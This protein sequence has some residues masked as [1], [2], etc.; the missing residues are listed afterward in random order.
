ML[1]LIV[2]AR[3]AMPGGGTLRL[4]TA[5]ATTAE[6]DRVVLEISDTGEGMDEDTRQRAFEPFFTTKPIGRGSGLGLAQVY[7]FVEQSGGTVIIESE[8]GTGTT[9]RLFLPRAESDITS[10]K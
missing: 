6:G 1:N 8:A 3:D 4:T 2:N 10:A 7:G 9:V 5:N